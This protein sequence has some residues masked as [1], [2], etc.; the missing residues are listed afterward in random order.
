MW[1]YCCWCCFFSSVSGGRISLW[2]DICRDSPWPAAVP[3]PSLN[4]STRSVAVSATQLPGRMSCDDY[5]WLPSCWPAVASTR[6]RP[7]AAAA[8]G[9]PP[10]LSDN[11]PWFHRIPWTTVTEGI[12]WVLTMMRWWHGN[13]IS[14]CDGGDDGG[15]MECVVRNLSNWRVLDRVPA[16]DA[17]NSNWQEYRVYDW[18]EGWMNILWW[19]E[20]P[21]DGSL[22]DCVL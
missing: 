16:H 20:F 1:G 21:G 3:S 18:V 5:Y 11:L 7:C 14:S 4:L 19:K 8:V 22:V 9:P 12:R 17:S 15:K 13:R 6:Q 2:I 10:A